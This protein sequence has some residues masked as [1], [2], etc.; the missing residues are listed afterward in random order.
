[1]FI[2]LARNFVFDNK[3]E[4]ERK[5]G[6]TG[7]INTE[8]NRTKGGNKETQQQRTTYQS[9][10]ACSEKPLLLTTEHPQTRRSKTGKLCGLTHNIWS[11][12]GTSLTFSSYEEIT[13]AVHAPQ[14]FFPCI[15]LFLKVSE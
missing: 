11:G 10:S 5:R 2:A 3:D 13:L 9:I 1:M 8:K 15:L 4:E 14:K 7:E 6:C 12:T